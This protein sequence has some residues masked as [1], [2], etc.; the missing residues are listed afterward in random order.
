MYHIQEMIESIIK[1]PD[2]CESTGITNDLANELHQEGLVN[3]LV[4]L[5][6]SNEYKDTS[7]C[8]MDCIRIRSKIKVSQTISFQIIKE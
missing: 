7:C 5:L 2:L 1:N 3:V 6:E 8:D 4:P